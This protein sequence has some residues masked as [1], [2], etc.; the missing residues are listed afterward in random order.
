MRILSQQE[1]QKTQGAV[2]PVV[3]R[4]AGGALVGAG[5]HAGENYIADRPL[6]E[7]IGYAAAVG[8]IGNAAT[9]KL[10]QLSGGGWPSNAAWRPG[11]MA[12]EHGVQL[13]NPVNQQRGNNHQ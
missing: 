5:M 11:M 2:W 13:G 4:A 10:V 8:A 7:G 12:I 3:G 6:T 1:I 9:G